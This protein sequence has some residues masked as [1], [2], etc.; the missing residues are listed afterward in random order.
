MTEPRNKKTYLGDGAF[1]RFDG[2]HV[3]L[4]TE[5]GISETNRVALDPEVLQAFE[6]WLRSPCWLRARA[7]E[8]GK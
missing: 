5:D 8:E 1:V 4:T 2:Y 6:E 7:A 3:L